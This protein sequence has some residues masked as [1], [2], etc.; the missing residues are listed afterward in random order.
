MP[1]LE[2][3]SQTSPLTPDDLLN[4]YKLLIAARKARKNVFAFYNCGDL[5][6][7]ELKLIV[8]S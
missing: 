1:A 5:S 3:Q 2:Y 6:G 4:S 8:H 7:G